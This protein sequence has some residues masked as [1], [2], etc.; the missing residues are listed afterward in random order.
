MKSKIFSALVVLAGIML[1]YSC[2]K[3]A[4]TT[5]PV[6][7][8][9][10]NNPF[11]QMLNIPYKDSGATAWDSK[12]GDL[13]ISIIVDSSVNVNHTGTYSVDY[14]VFDA[15][16]NKATATRTVIVINESDPLNGG[17]FVRDSVVGNN[18]GIRNYTVN[19]NASP[20]INN[21]IFIDNFGG[22]GS[23]VCVYGFVNGNNIAIPS[24]NPS[25][26]IYPGTVTGIGITSN[27]SILGIIYNI[28]Y[29]PANTGS[30]DGFADY[31]KL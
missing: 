5:P 8:I 14:T 28:T 16:G 4:E 23:G 11:I 1:V 7:T 9:K 15:A 30:D 29:I 2:Y 6:I 22:L 24:Q 13:T 17:Y 20:T 25:N 19:V 18:P 31:T 10:G 26:M 12:D 21:K 27:D 3:P